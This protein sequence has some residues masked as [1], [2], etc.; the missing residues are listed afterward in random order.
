MFDR[1]K[2]IKAIFTLLK[3]S[4]IFSRDDKEI[5]SS[6]ISSLSDEDIMNLGKILAYEHNNRKSLDQ[7]LITDFLKNL[8]KS[9]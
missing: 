7:N 8:K 4:I 6:K 5:I 1:E 3:F 2:K 9:N